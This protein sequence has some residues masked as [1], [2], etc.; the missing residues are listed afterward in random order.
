MEF[1]PAAPQSNASELAPLAIA[2]PSG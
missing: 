1:V 2:E